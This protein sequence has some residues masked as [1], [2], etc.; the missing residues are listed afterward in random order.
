MSQSGTARSRVWAASVTGGAAFVLLLLLL[1]PGDL[2]SA[3]AILAAT[4]LGAALLAAWLMR[5]GS[6]PRSAWGVGCFI[7]GLLSTAVAVGARVQ[8]DLWMS[9]SHYA[10]DL[11]RAFGSVAHFVSALAAR[12]GIIALILAAA[13][14]ALSYWLLNPPHR[15]A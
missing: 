13:L 5:R 11:D 15:K 3:I 9:Q 6:P 14:F 7:N 10:E 4:A 1:M 2:A 12:V 8:N